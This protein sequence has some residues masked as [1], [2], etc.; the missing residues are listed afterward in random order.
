MSKVID[1]RQIATLLTAL[2]YWQ[3]SGMT[4][5][6]GIPPYLQTLPCDYADSDLLDEQE[7]NVLYE[8]LSTKKF[9][10]ENYQPKVAVLHDSGEL[11][12]LCDPEVQVERIATDDVL[13]LVDE[14]RDEL[15]TILGDDF[16]HLKMAA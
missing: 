13:G 7:I 11:S 10:A 6:S 14:R 4:E 3:N 9:R 1:H 2:R 12:V 5:S 15:L 8:A 16:K